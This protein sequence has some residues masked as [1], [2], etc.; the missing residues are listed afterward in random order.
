[1][2]YFQ[3]K[4]KTSATKGSGKCIEKKRTIS[5]FTSIELDI[6]AEVTIKKGPSTICRIQAED[7][8]I[9]LINTNSKKSKLYISSNAKYSNLKPIKIDM[10]TPFID[11]AI[12]NGS[13]K[14]HLIDVAKGKIKLN[15]N[16]SGTISAEGQ[17]ENLIADINGSGKI[18]GKTLRTSSADT[19]INGSGKIHLNMTG[20]SN[21]KSR[22]LDM[23]INGSGKIYYSGKPDK[24]EASING[25]GKISSTDP[26]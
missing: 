12:I 25:S 11:N 3:K 21:K 7:N 18:Q 1:M 19:S 6:N 20:K 26:S 8:I 22:T 5:N 15:C 13:G 14:I 9:P 24:I 2:K 17:A 10:E 4:N 16:G 23:S